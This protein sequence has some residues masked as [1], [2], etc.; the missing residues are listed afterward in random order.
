MP[1]KGETNSRLSVCCSR[2]ATTVAT[3]PPRQLK[4][5]AAPT[6]LAGAA[7]SKAFAVVRLA[8]SCKIAPL[9]S[10][11]ETGKILHKIK[12]R[13]RRK[14]SIKI[15]CATARVSYQ[16]F[17]LNLLALLEFGNW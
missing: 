6:K 14:S 7:F 1:L 15:R 10:K 3:L 16:Y 4:N 17:I 11:I 12:L 8:R 9:I 13:F 5:K 2:S